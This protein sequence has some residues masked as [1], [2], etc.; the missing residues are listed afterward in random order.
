M[1]SGEVDL[2]DRLVGTKPFV[3]GMPEG[4][5][6]IYRWTVGIRS[7]RYSLNVEMGV[8]RRTWT[9]YEALETPVNAGSDGEPARRH[10]QLQAMAKLKSMR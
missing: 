3:R 4:A 9:N 1:L 6:D 7:L 10:G 8:R 2:V 5:A